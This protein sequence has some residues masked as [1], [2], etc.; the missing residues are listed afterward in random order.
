MYPDPCG[1]DL[2]NAVANGADPATVVPDIF[3]VVRGVTKPI[4]PAGQVFSGV[5]GP[6][7]AAAACAVQHG[8]VR[9]TTAAVIRAGGGSVFW[10]PETSPR[11]TLNLQHVNVTE[12]VA[13]AFS[14]PIAN[15]VPK[16]LR[17]DEGR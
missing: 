6:T 8:Q 17:L 2:A 12:I 5:V 4:P 11:G 7:L 9:M 10:V 13:T 3:V 15:P 16:K 1:S 14:E